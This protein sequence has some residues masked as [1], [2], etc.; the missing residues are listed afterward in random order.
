VYNTDLAFEIEV[1]E[2]ETL[3]AVTAISKLDATEHISEAV[4][5]FR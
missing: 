2:V 4:H 5:S 3:P 1:G